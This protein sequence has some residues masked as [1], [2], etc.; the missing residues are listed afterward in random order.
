MVHAL[1]PVRKLGFGLLSPRGIDRLNMAVE[2]GYLV[3]SILFVIGTALFFPVEFLE[4]FETGC[5]LFEIGSLIFMVL[6]FYVEV[7]GYF[8][9]K[10]KDEQRNVTKRELIEQGLYCG[11]SF[12]FL[13]GTFLFDPP[14]AHNLSD[15]LQIDPGKV[16][17]T[18]A[19]FFMIG[20]LMFSL[21]SYVNA[22]SIFEAPRMFRKHLLTVTTFY[23]FGGLLFVAGTMGY[24]HA[25]EPNKTMTWVATWMYMIGCFFYVAGTGLSFIRTVASQQ[26]SWERKQARR[27]AKRCSRHMA[28]A[29]NSPALRSNSPQHRGEKSLNDFSIVVDPLEVEAGATGDTA[30]DFERGDLEEAEQRLAAQLE[31]VLGPDAGR[32]LAAAL[33]DEDGPLEEDLFGAFWRSVWSTSDADAEHSVGTDDLE[34]QAEDAAKISSTGNAQHAAPMPSVLGQQKLSSKTYRD[35]EPFL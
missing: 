1:K 28:K 13:V 9:R 31:L 20:S 14:L 21:G 4:D 15:G 34:Q 29:G 19:V 30:E 17:N 22:L 8:A 23:Q 26:V 27:D 11:G 3:G 2:F 5:K 6:T 10:R 33:R 7:D 18:A 32:E 25:F 24:V 35:N 12:V 16:E